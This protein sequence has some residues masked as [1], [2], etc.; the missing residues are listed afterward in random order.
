MELKKKEPKIIAFWFG[1]T[2]MMSLDRELQRDPHTKR[3]PHRLMQAGSS[4]LLPVTGD[5]GRS[6]E[7]FT[8]K[9]CVKQQ[10]S[11]MIAATS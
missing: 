11:A 9:V 1:A 8:G 2:P 6:E 4:P 5:P 3:W 7:N 10:A